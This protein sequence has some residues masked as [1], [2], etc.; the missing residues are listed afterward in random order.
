MQVSDNRRKITVGIFIFIGLIIFVIGVYTLGNLKKTF[1]KSITI[2]VVFDDIQGLK[3]GDNIW[4][5]GVKVGTIRKIQFYGTSQVQVFMNIEKEAQQYIHKDALA[6]ISSDGLIGNKIIV[7]TSG[8]PKFPLI[9]SGDQIRVN[10]TLSTDQIMRTFQKS[11]K[12]LVDITTDIRK[13]SANL[14]AGKG[15]AGALLADEQMAQNFKSVLLNLKS[16]TEATNKMVAQMNA[17]S[18]KL[19][20]SGSLADKIFTDTVLYT[21]IQASANQLKEASGVAAALTENL[22]DASLKLQTTDNPAGL[23]LNDQKSAEQIRAILINLESSSRNLNEDLK[24]LQSNFLFRGY[25]KKQK[26]AAAKTAAEPKN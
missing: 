15:T 22:N 2:N 19:N 12:N 9:E 5:S 20:T 13:L 26:K 10:P 21:T 25:F 18:R 24:A 7:V 11:N 23:L 16:A 8:S 3:T 6:S 1:I 17:F 14:V 4:F